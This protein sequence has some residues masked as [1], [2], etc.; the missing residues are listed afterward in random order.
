VCVCVCVCLDASDLTELTKTNPPID[1]PCQPCRCPAWRLS[2]CSLLSHS[3]YLLTQRGA[4]A[5]NPYDDGGSHFTTA[6]PPP[7]E[8]LPAATRP[9]DAPEPST[10]SATTTTLQLLG[11]A[12]DTFSTD[13]LTFQFPRFMQTP[14]YDHRLLEWATPIYPPA[15]SSAAAATATAVDN[16]SA[17]FATSPTTD[18]HIHRYPPHPSVILSV[19]TIPSLLTSLSQRPTLSSLVDNHNHHHHHHHCRRRPI[20]LWLWRDGVCTC[21]V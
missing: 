7:P 11:L 6:N 21:T 20:P 9:N 17:L 2:L 1:G 14:A 3:L 12:N 18:Y 5:D 15:T 8:F 19:H 10:T 13:N 16:T 4:M